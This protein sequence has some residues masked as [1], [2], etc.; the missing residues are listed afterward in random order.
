MF[1]SE[2]YIFISTEQVSRQISVGRLL[3]KFKKGGEEVSVF[4]A[5]HFDFK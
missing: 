3:F 4:Y 2:L 1:Y 5:A